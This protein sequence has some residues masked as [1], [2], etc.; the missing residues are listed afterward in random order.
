MISK[1]SSSESKAFKERRYWSQTQFSQKTNA[2]VENQSFTSSAELSALLSNGLL[3][4]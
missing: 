1:F 4:H 3:N 2:A